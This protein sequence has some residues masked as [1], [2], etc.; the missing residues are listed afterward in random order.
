MSKQSESL[1]WCWWSGQDKGCQS[2]L[3]AFTEKYYIRADPVNRSR[4]D[5]LNPADLCLLV[6]RRGGLHQAVHVSHISDKFAAVLLI[7]L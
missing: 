1:T 5:T 4:T 6:E 2:N 3:A 7:Q